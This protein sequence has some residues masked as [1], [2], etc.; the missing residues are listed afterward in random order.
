MKCPLLKITRPGL[1][2]KNV[3]PSDDCIKEECAWWLKGKDG[4]GKKWAGCAV[5]YLVCALHDIAEMMPH[6][7][8]STK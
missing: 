3:N 8:Q 7:G 1:M 5:P 2:L 6:A 4:K